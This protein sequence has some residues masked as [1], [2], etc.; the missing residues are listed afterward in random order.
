MENVLPAATQEVLRVRAATMRRVR[1]FFDERG[2]CEVDTP[3]LSADS[4]VD[5][6][7]DPVPVMLPD[8]ACQLG[9]GR[10]LWLQT[11]PEFGMKRMLCGGLTAIY[12]LAHAFRIGERGQQ[13]NPEFAMLEW[14][15]VGDDMQAGMS[16]LAE[17]ATEF[18]GG[19]SSQISFREAFQR[20]LGI[21]PFRDEISDLAR[22]AGTRSVSLP[23]GAEADRELLVECLLSELVQPRLGI[24]GP[25]I[26]YDYPVWQSA[27][28]KTRQEGDVEVAE[29]F[30]LYYAGVE[31]ANGYH[32]LT[33]GDELLRR[34]RRINQLRRGDGRFEI[35]D[36]SR[37]LAAM[38]RGLL[39]G[40]A[41]VALGFDRLMM[42]LTHTD[43]ID[44]VIPFPIERA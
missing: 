40:C 38:Q 20:E 36:E 24:E 29:R 41:G 31:L 6:H 14:Y 4:V 37:L 13:H 7:L 15:R 35:A 25:T 2:F 42:V 26:V 3:V 32:E 17:F 16:L 30:E 19:N 10:A 23:D 22:V 11:S 27:L 43:K 39:P 34:N 8:D 12:Q 18:L 28:A 44:R 1:A 5:R 9:K 21:D 33:D